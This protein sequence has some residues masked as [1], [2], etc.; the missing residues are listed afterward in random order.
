MTSLHN[1]NQ[2]T[3]GKENRPFDELDHRYGPCKSIPDNLLEDLALEN[4]RKNGKGTTIKDVMHRF[5]IHK[6]KLNVDLSMQSKKKKTNKE[7]FLH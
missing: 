2:P 5:G 4:Y 7:F 6:K 1:K 3:Q